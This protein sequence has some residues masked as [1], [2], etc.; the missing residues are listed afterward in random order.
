MAFAAAFAEIGPIQAVGM[1]LRIARC[2]L[3][4]C[5]TR[6]VAVEALVI[7]IMSTFLFFKSSSSSGV[8]SGGKMVS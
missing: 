7:V 3:G 4:Q 5:L 6:F 8:D 1:V 2:C